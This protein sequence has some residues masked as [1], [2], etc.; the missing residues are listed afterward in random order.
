MSSNN[1]IN[2]PL[3]LSPANGGTG[4]ANPTANGIAIAN[5]SSNYT[6]VKLANGQVLFGKSSG[7]PVAY[8]M[9]D[10][11]AYSFAGGF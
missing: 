9:P 10:I 1:S 7:N 8:Y 6:F 3:P 4:V 11:W 2:A 5:G